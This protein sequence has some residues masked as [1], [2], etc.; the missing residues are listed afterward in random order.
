MRA[1]TVRGMEVPEY[2]G[3]G[4]VGESKERETCEILEVS[5]D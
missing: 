4:P 5:L 1:T 2:A 3:C